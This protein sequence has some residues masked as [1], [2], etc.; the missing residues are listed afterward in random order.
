MKRPSVKSSL[1]GIVAGMFLIAAILSWISISSMS[2]I[3]T[4]NDEVID[5]WLPSVARSK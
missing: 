4:N 2:E 3:D 5:N 1:I